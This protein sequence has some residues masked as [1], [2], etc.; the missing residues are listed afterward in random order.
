[1][2]VDDYLIARNDFRDQGEIDFG[3]LPLSSTKRWI[4]AD[5]ITPSR[6]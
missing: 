5:L 3:H 2:I 6:T 1:V 4:A